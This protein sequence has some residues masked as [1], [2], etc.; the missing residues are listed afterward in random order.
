MRKNSFVIGISAF[1]HDS[2]VCLFKNGKLVFACEEERFSG[3]KHDSSFPKRTLQYVFRKYRLTRDKIDCVCYYENPKLKKERV[4]KNLKR[5]ILRAPKYCINAYT[6]ISKREREIHKLLNNISE[7]VF[8]SN[9]HESH[10]YYGFAT[11]LLDEANVVSI[12]GV[13][14]LDTLTYGVNRKDYYR[15]K[16]LSEYPHSLGLFYSAMT[17][18]LG[19]KP[20]EGEY[21]LMGLASFGKKNH[22]TSLLRELIKFEDG[23]LWC[24]M[25][26][27]CWDRNDKIMFD[28]SLVSHLGI[29]PRD[30]NDK[31]TREYQLLAF[32]VQKVYE[33]ILFSI[34]QETYERNP[35]RNLVLTGGCAYNGT[36]NGKIE[37]NTSYKKVWVPSAPSDA[38][39][40][41]GACVNY[42]IKNGRKNFKVTRNPFLGPEYGYTKTIKTIEQEKVVFY[43]KN[44]D[45]IRKVAL[46]L[47]QDKVVGWFQGSIEFGAR[48]L[49]NRSILASPSS[50]FMQDKINKVI[51]KRE[52]FRPFAPMVRKDSQHIYFDI[53]DDVP[54]MNKVVS[55]REQ[56]RKNLPA[57]T[58]VDGTA[59]VQ[60]V[61]PNNKIDKL[62][63]E[64]EEI[65]GL[66][67]LLNTSFNVK[68]QTMVLTPEQA[69][70]TFKDTEMDIL[71]LGNYVI[72]K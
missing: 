44:D 54:Y 22:F 48:A 56:Y 8:Y 15:H 17:S 23:K 35:N 62:L 2:S 39:S 68:G 34:L 41:I 59:R 71:V 50:P 4:W 30:V 58:H 45:L 53:K 64:M 46:E 57:V 70:Q 20:N 12:D 13:G 36:A 61:F 1:Y 63:L 55:V 66:P 32:S 21:K 38:G 9:H 51:K 67:I 60:T 25:T 65:T 40:C 69:L 29:Q 52:G 11:S 49:G 31:I 19:F 18:Y 28:V 24:D 5:N 37:E 43:D 10:I 42:F 3:K 14:E 6:E 7:N 26:K 47:S 33:E 27:F 72:E 16:T